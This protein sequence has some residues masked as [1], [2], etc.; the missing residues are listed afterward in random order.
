MPN[1]Y[2]PDTMMGMYNP[3]GPIGQ[4]PQPT[5]FMPQRQ[6]HGVIRVHGEEGAKAFAMTANDEAILL[7]ETQP[8]VWLKTTD[9]AGYPTVTGYSIAPFKTD[10]KVIDVQQPVEE[11]FENKVLARLE[12]L[13]RKIENVQSH[14]QSVGYA[15]AK[16]S[17][18][19]FKSDQ[20][21]DR[22]A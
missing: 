21:H 15:A 14:A 22:N 19:G 8:V 3:T 20:K 17:G 4:Y 2:Y 11:S 7:D 6:K 5:P 1:Q 18:T 16:Q 10:P 9:G 13:E 12:Q